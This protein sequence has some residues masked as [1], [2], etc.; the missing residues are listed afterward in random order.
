LVIDGEIFDDTWRAATSLPEIL[1]DLR[2][3]LF[4]TNARRG[5]TLIFLLFGPKNDF[6][7]YFFLQ[8]SRYQEHSMIISQ[9]QNLFVLI[10][11]RL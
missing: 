1:G 6:S 2:G 5:L 4:S 7:F 11:I 9:V 8:K 10:L 3:G